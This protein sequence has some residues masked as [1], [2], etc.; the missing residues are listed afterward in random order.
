MNFCQGCNFMLY[1]KLEKDQKKLT[2]YCKHCG[3]ESE[4]ITKTDD[5]SICV[6]KKNYSD[7]FLAEKTFT[8][9]FTKFDPT[10]PRINNIKCVNKDCLTNIPDNPNTTYLSKTNDDSFSDEEKEYLE[11][12]YKSSIE[13][14]NFYNNN[15]FLVITFNSKDIEAI[16]NNFEEENKDK[17]FKILVKPPKESIREIIF[18][19]Y[20]Y[21]NLKYLYLCTSCNTSW[22]NE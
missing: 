13:N 15:H 19:K 10:L 12:K 6:Y 21:T 14:I 3:L 5:K 2:N 17:D 8:N 22:N 9:K 11:D 1:T 7:D 16:K 18:I 4:Y 20:D